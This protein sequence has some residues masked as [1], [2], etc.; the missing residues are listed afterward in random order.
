[1]KRIRDIF[2]LNGR[3]KLLALFATVAIWL[4]VVAN[5]EEPVNFAIKVRFE[6]GADR[7]VT[8]TKSPE[9]VYVQAKGSIFAVA[10]V[11]SSD[12][13]VV[14]DVSRREAG[15]TVYFIDDRDIPFSQILKIERISPREISFLVS[16]K[17]ARTV[18]VDPVLDG[19]PKKGYK[20]VSVESKPAMVPVVGPEE[21]IASL[22]S[23][24]TER[25]DISNST[26]TVTKTLRVMPGQPGV[27]PVE[28]DS[29]VIVT[30]VVERDIREMTFSRVPFVLDGGVPSDMTPQFITV[31]VRGPVETLE[32]LAETGLNAFVENL[33]ARLYVV[34]RYYFKDLPADVEVVEMEQVRQIT[35]RK[36][37]P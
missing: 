27:T 9:E 17:V 11:R 22:E 8:M 21:T 4:G 33:P 28:N 29:T 6:A 18:M 12:H 7:V 15:R 13:E 34:D 25:L 20:I 3:E 1:M 5:R 30:V 31:R 2:T 10:Q 36:K 23:V 24:A 26:A 32:K 35:I 16:K 37:N 19:Q 14:V